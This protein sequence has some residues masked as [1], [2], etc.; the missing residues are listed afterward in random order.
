[1]QMERC[2]CRTAVAVKILLDFSLIQVTPYVSL[3]HQSKA[4][5][6]EI[7]SSLRFEPQQLVA[8]GCD[9]LPGWHLL[10]GM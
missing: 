9:W 4:V 8:Q 3:A 5:T 7:N 2:D 6:N 1:M 10:D